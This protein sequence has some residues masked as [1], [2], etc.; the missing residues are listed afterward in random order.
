MLDGDLHIN[1]GTYKGVGHGG[2]YFS[3][4]NSSCYIENATLSSAKYD[5]E[6]KKD[7]RY[8]T[9]ENGVVTHEQYDETGFYVGDSASVCNTSVYLDNCKIVSGRQG[10][11]V[12]RGTS[13]EQNNSVYMSNCTVVG[14]NK[15]VR[16]D[17]NT[18]KV[19]LGFRNNITTENVSL[20]EVVTNTREVYIK[21]EA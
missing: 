3:K 6:F 10:A 16:V 9:E 4:P 11:F 2:I 20:P 7:Y 1:G 13:N 18:H 5:G 15:T 21:E 14:E 8:F 12:L 17:N 19:F